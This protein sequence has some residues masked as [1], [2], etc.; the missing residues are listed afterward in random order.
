MA[1]ELVRMLYFKNDCLFIIN[2]E[3]VCQEHDKKMEGIHK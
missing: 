3:S 1:T 2:R